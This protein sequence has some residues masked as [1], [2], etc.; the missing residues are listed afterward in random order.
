MRKTIFVLFMGLLILTPV[1]AWTEKEKMPIGMAV[2]FTDHAA[3]A[4]IA[5]DKGWFEEEGLKPVTYHYVT[6]MALAASLSRGDIQVAYIC[7]IPAINAYA[8][9]RVPIKIVSGTHRY[10]YGFVVNPNR[11]KTFKD[12]EKSD[13]RIG[14]TQVGSPTDALLHKM[15]EKY[16]LDRNKILDKVQRMNP[17][18][19]VMAIRMGKLDASINPEHWP[20]VAE[21]IGFKMML[22]SQDLWPNMQGSVLVVKEDLIKN[23]PEIVRRLLKVTGKAI[24]FIKENPEEA[25]LVMA[26]QLKIAGDRVTPLDALKGFEKLSISPQTVFRSMKRLEYSINIDLNVI[27]ET[28]DYMVELGYIKSSFRAE[29]I[30]DLRFLK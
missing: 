15:I 6:G 3:C 26:R 13:I 21:E 14:C 12:L 22:K 16:G 20:S 25:S 11:V 27:Q 18:K 8:N 23:H 19:Q 1:R 10:G 30:L 17:P 24:N 9:A 5:M 28:I 2:E 7:L 4:Y 29:D